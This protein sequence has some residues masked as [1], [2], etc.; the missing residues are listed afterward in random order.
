ML[1]S[2]VDPKGEWS[3]AIGAAFVA[4]GSIEH[5][6]VVCLREIP[7]D[8]IGRFSKALRLA[9]RVDLL[10]ELLEPHSQSECVA[11][12]EKLREVKVLAKTRNLIAHNPLVLQIHEDGKGN[13]RFGSAITAIHKEGHLISLPE[14]QEFATACDK[15]ASELVGVSINAFKALGLVAH[16]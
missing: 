2:I 11:L 4:F 12:S 16:V 14:A 6:T 8:S 7:K 3:A 5:T 13:R 9:A 1:A 15:L 10:L